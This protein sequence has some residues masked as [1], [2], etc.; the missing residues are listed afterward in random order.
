MS[1]GGSGQYW[2]ARIRIAEKAGTGH[3]PMAGVVASA[4]FMAATGF[5]VCTVAL[6]AGEMRSEAHGRL[7]HPAMREFTPIKRAVKDEPPGKAYWC[8]KRHSTYLSDHAQQ[9]AAVVMLSNCGYGSQAVRFFLHER[10][11]GWSVVQKRFEKL[12]SGRPVPCGRPPVPSDIRCIGLARLTRREPPT[13]NRADAKF[14]V[15]VTRSRSGFGPFREGAGSES[16]SKL[17]SVYGKPSR[18]ARIHQYGCRMH[19]PRIGLVV[20]LTTYGLAEGP[21][22]NGFFEGASLTDRRWH[23]SSGVHPGSRARLAK[24]HA[25]RNC[26][27]SDSYKC[28]GAKGYVL[29]LHPSECAAGLYPTVMAQVK[30]GRVRTLEVF[31]HS[32]E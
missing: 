31:K 2:R 30:H 9:W 13:A 12:G 20:R 32:C 17:R 23:T 15:P 19:W 3:R 7:G 26:L 28:L 14:V 25:V 22:T 10:R 5:L 29:G 27:H 18:T 8:P 16:A 24:R 11:G 4:M 21:C 6:A 1:T